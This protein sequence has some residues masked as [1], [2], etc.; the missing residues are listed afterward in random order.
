MTNKKVVEKLIDYTGKTSTT[1][2][3]Q[4][5]TAHIQNIEQS[6]YQFIADSYQYTEHDMSVSEEV[7]EA[8]DVDEEIV[9]E[10]STINY[11]PVLTS[12]L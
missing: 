1:S 6:N 5:K 9:K 8:T 3:F 11:K 2:D 7:A 12:A 4:D 10:I